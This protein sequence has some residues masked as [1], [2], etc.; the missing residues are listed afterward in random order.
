MPWWAIR[1]TN[2]GRGFMV[3]TPFR[4]QDRADRHLEKYYGGNGDTFETDS[5]DRKVAAREIRAQM[6]QQNNAAWGKNFKHG[7]A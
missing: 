3:D 6:A 2:T 1:Y 4:S 7:K 5:W